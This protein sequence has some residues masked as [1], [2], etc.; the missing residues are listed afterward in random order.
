M[1]RFV[2]GNWKMNGSGFEGIAWMQ[3]VKEGA[4]G[5]S[6]VDLA[7]FPPFTLLPVLA[8]DA[9][10]AGVMLGAQDVYFEA[11]GAFTGEISVSMLLE[12]GCEWVIVGHSERRHVIGESD[13]TVRRKLSAALAG[14]LSVVLCVGERLEERDSGIE[15]DTV[16]TQLASALGGL[17]PIDPGRLVIAYEPVW[18]IG[19][20]RN[21]TPA[22]AVRMHDFI[23]S[24]LRG[25][26]GDGDA[27]GCRVIYG[28]SVNPG[29]AGDL[30]R[31]P[32]IEG[33]LVGGASLDAASFLSIAGASRDG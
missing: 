32:S 25:L 27:P 17:D 24:T 31:E 7:L 16:R 8:E 22:Q 3:S 30:L 15:E 5:L 11:R 10:E 33:A 13:G 2:G 1:N 19:T 23:R 20:G 12:A 28:G 21:A 18:A 14:G 29:N 26:V 9:R 4:G 6:G